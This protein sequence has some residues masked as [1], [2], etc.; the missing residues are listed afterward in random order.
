MQSYQS[1][2]ELAGPNPSQQFTELTQMASWRM[3]HLEW[4]EKTTADINRFFDSTSGKQASIAT[5]APKT[6]TTP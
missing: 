4:R 1:V 3:K 6:G 5:D 2:V